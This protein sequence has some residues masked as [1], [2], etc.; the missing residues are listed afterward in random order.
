MNKSIEL[1]NKS[2]SKEIRD[3]TIKT[4]DK[5]KALKTKDLSTSKNQLSNY[6]T[7]SNF[8]KKKTHESKD[9]SLLGSA[10]KE[11]PKKSKINI[12]KSVN[13][14]NVNNNKSIS[15][16]KNSNEL[17]SG[18]KTFSG[19]GK[20]KMLS[21]SL[22]LK[23]S[24]KK[25]S[26]KEEVF[27]SNVKVIPNKSKRLENDLKF[28]FSLDYIAKDSTFKSKVKDMCKN[29]FCE[30]FNKKIFS[31][32]FKKQVEALKE[33]KEQLE[34]N[35]NIVTYFDNLDLILKVMGIKLNGNLNPTSVK[36]LFEFFDALYFIITE[37]GHPLNEIESLIIISLLVDKLSINNNALKEHLMKLLN[38]FMELSDANKIMINILNSSLGKNN[39]IKTDILDL[40]YELHLRK[41]LNISTKNYVKILGKYICI[42][43]NIIKTK[44]LL[45]F[46]D[47]FEVIGEELFY[48]LDFLTDKDKEFLANN[49]IQ[50]NSNNDSEEEVELEKQPSNLDS[51]DEEDGNFEV[52]PKKRDSISNSIR[53]NVLNG[54]NNTEK[55]LL[56]N[57]KKL[58][59]KNESEQLSSIILIHEIIYQKYQENKKILIP[60]IDKI[61]KTFIQVLHGILIEKELKNIPVK[62]TRYLTTVLLKIASNQELISHISYKVLSEITNELLNYLLIQGFDKI[63]DKQEEGNIIFKSINSTMLRI[64]ENCNKTDIILVLLDIIKKHQKGGNKKI[65]NLAV[66][67]LLKA[68]ENINKIINNLDLKKI[69]N[70]MHLIVYNY[71]QLY[72][73]LKN[74]Q[75]TD[76][77]ILKFIRNFINN[78]VKIKEHDIWN[79]YNDSIKKSDKEDKYIIY[80]I[81]SCLDNINKNDKSLSLNISNI[82]NIDNFNSVNNSVDSN[83]KKEKGKELENKIKEIDLD[84]KK[85]KEKK[86][87]EKSKIEDLKKKWNEVK[88]K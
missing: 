58:Y 13:L 17:S 50:E 80:W 57:L 22:I 34:K 60:N 28:K 42:N 35:I 26:K 83:V 32:D 77:I 2:Y 72:P 70:E 7:I 67:C 1:N 30:E 63:K 9:S 5:D 44:V 45:I 59:A 85:E 24:D 6:K 51:S 12:N 66:K 86:D 64:I 3:K 55:D 74:K 62:F 21:N 56:N 36:N 79:I 27:C 43:D 18:K 11:T 61:I 16:E 33:M 65:S 20:L 88:P 71:L 49:L 54:A 37:K 81:K 23:K 84:N 15:K 14:N 39:K 69:L 82:S 47:I 4:T 87:E 29:L 48:I 25:N 52:G 38:E 46:K 53:N 41:K 76:D 31:D 75:S 73:E 10:Q 8:N 78:I 19:L 40:V 68:T